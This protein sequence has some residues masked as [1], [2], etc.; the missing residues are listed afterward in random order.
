MFKSNWYL[1]LLVLICLP[2]V[3]QAVDGCSISGK[4]NVCCEN[5]GVGPTCA[6]CTSQ[7]SP[8]T[9]GAACDK[10][11]TDCGVTADCTSTISANTLYSH[12]WFYGTGQQE[13][14]TITWANYYSNSKPD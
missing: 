7:C 4:I 10:S 6:K 5:S 3:S 8:N 11:L 2:A 13:T 12:R 14:S 9:K 1:I